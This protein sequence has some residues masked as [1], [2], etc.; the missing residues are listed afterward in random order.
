M[1]TLKPFDERFKNKH[2]TINDILKL[3]LNQKT[4]NGLSYKEAICCTI[5][6]KALS[7]DIRAFESII[8]I[9]KDSNKE[10]TILT[11]V[12]NIQPV[13]TLKD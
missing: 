12:I 5:I 3:L 11:P 10:N 7:G 4:E 2:K 8:H 13:S 1:D 9:L 6:N